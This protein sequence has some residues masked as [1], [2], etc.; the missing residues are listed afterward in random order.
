MP[1]FSVEKFL[2]T[3]HFG[4]YFFSDGDERMAGISIWNI[5]IGVEWKVKAR[6]PRFSEK[7][8]LNSVKDCSETISRLNQN[9]YPHQHW[10]EN[11]EQ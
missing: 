3:R 7:K 1:T 11:L 10:D 6:K 4:P 2:K 9:R 5:A 8:Y